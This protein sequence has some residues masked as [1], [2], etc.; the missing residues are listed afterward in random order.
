V[1]IAS[2]TVTITREGRACVLAVGGELDI[3]TAPALA[4]QA[5]AALRQPAQ[6]WIIDLAGLE[7]IDC[8]GVRALAAAARAVPPSC[9]VLVRGA[10]RWV[11]KILD[12]LAV[13][14]ERPGPAALDRAEWLILELQ[15]VRSWVQETQ[16]DSRALVSESRQARARRVAI[17]EHIQLP[18]ACAHRTPGG[19][20]FA[21]Y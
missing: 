8:S 12:L 21:S 18:A 15:V 11:R 16:A 3:A 4:R 19:G 6:R 10:G 2:L 1:T 20:N 7:F 5:A 17:R 14:L 13:P 9:P